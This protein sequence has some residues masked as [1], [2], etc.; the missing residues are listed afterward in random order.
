MSRDKEVKNLNDRHRLMI[1]EKDQ[2]EQQI[3]LLEK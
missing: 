2:L 3:I 1:E